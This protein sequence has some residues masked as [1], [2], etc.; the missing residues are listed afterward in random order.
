[1]S[2][3][4]ETAKIIIQSPVRILG[5]SGSLR[6]ASFNTGMLRYISANL[7]KNVDLQV[8]DI[9]RLPLFN[10]DLNDMKDESKDPLSVVAFR[11][12]IRQSDAILF[13]SAE[14]N[15]GMSGVLKNA[16]DWG[17]RSANGNAF[18]GKTATIIGGGGGLGTGRA[19]YQL[20]QTGVFLDL[21]FLTKPEVMIRI[22]EPN[23]INWDT[24][25]LLDNTWKPR[26]IAQVEALR[27][28]TY[29][30]KLGTEA[31]KNLNDNKSKL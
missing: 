23:T 19:Q 5:I 1:M 13:A 14:Y 17:S 4:S 22:F 16:I 11:K 8:A 10:G 18:A 21:Q 20:R 30:H 26:L 29:Q 3:F 31:F 7:P 15:Y 2:K 12:Q 28:F 25:E 9:S 24:G 27:D 6:K